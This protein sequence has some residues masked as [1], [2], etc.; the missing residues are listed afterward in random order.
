M[1]GRTPRRTSSG[2]TSAA[3]PSRP[4]DSARPRGAGLLDQRQ[5]LVEVGRHPVEVA[6]LRGGA[7]SGSR[8]TRPRACEA[9]GHGR[10]ERL[11]A[12]HAAEPAGQDPLARAGRRHSAGGRP[13][14]RSRRCPARSPGCRCRSRSR[15][16]SGRT[17]SGPS[18]SSSWKR[19]QV[20][21]CATRLELAI[22][23][24]GASAWVR[25]TPT[26]LPDCTS[27]VS[28]SLEPL[29]RLD[30]HVVAAPV[31][32][33]PADAAIDHEL[34]RALGDL[35][36]EVVHQHPK[37]RLGLPA[38][39]AQR[40]PA[41]RPDHALVVA[42]VQ[43]HAPLSAA[44]PRPATYQSA[45][46]AEIAGRCDP[47]PGGRARAGLREHRSG[48]GRNA[49][50]EWREE[51]CSSSNPACRERNRALPRVLRALSADGRQESSA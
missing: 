40:L 15:R 9:P 33:R 17:S 31:A 38:A 32:R 35:G 50:G 37:R 39:R 14:R 29:E 51:T 4:T 44:P 46:A 13:R 34:L 45:G 8:G 10:G 2:K 30:Q 23:T 43:L 5:R 21:Q 20:A 24:R 28:S 47:G 3:L 48:Q 7:R 49:A 18:R 25:N 16:S 19:S 36:V 6:G 27:R 11:R 26:G 12:A 41:R 42:S 22:S 1:S